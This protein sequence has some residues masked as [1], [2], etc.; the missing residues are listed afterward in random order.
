M[1]TVIMAI[2]YQNNLSA[3]ISQLT[4]QEAMLR[5]APVVIVCCLPTE[6]GIEGEVMNIE[7]ALD[8]VVQQ[9]GQ[10]KDA[11][12]W[13][14]AT[15]RA[16]LVPFQQSGIPA[17]GL[18]CR[19]EPAEIIVDQANKLSAAMIIMG[20]RHLSPFNRLFKGS[21]SAAVLETASCPVLID[22][23]VGLDES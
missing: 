9:H 18:L 15:V 16:A 7:C 5:N 19:G 6:G 13:A 22:L 17:R 23:S 21:V 8:H 20:R 10:P 3:R 12:N 11:L 2:D 1:N 4:L 14:E